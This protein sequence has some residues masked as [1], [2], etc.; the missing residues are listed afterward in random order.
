MKVVSYIQ[1]DEK[2]SLRADIEALGMKG[3]ILNFKNH[4]LAGSIPVIC[5]L[6]ICENDNDDLISDLYAKVQIPFYDNREDLIE[7]LKARGADVAHTE[8]EAPAPVELETQSD[9]L[10]EQLALA[11]PDDYR[12]DGEPKAAFIKKV[13]SHC[14]LNG[15]VTNEEVLEL[16]RHTP[17]A[18][19]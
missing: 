14:K 18:S 4:A 9:L 13:I 2:P 17:R 10:L 8:D 11:E 7:F 12:I 15:K 3:I 1:A 6:V 5:D 16:W 19:E